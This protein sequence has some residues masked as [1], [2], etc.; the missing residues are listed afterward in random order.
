[1]SLKVDFNFRSDMTCRF[2][3]NDESGR[4]GE[5]GEYFGNIMVDNILWAIVLFDG[6]Y[7]PSFERA[8]DLLVEKKQWVQ[9]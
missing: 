4:A 9:L 2:K 1:M 5:G 8:I 7:D 3:T 6:E